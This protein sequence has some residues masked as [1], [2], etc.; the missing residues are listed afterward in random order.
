MP[1]KRIFD[2]FFS[3]LG[4][5]I[6][7]PLLGWIAWRIKREDG[8]PVFYRGERVGLRGKPFRI[9]KFRTM[10]VNAEKLGGSSTA[11]NDPRITSIGFKLRK[12]KLDELP[13][14]LNVFLGQMSLV[15]P[16]PEVKRYTDMFTAEEKAILSVRPG[17]TDWA[18]IWNPDEG[19]ILAGAADPDQAYL[20]LIRPTKV[21]LQRKYVQEQSF[22]TDLLILWETLIVLFSPEAKLK[23]VQRLMAEAQRN[24]GRVRNFQKGDYMDTRQLALKIRR[25]AVMMT[26]RGK[27]SHVASVLSM[28]DIVA[29]L[30]GRVLRKK[31]EDPNWLERDRF[32]LSKGHAGAGVYAAL[33]ETGYFP[34]D[35]LQNHCAQGSKLCGHV[36]HI[37]IPGVELSTGS[38]GHGLSVGAGIAYAAQ[39]DQKKFR[40]FVLL[41]D[42]ECDEGSNWEAILFAAHHRLGNLVAIIDYNKIQSLGAV[43]ETLALEPFAAK[44][45]AFGWQVKEVDGHDHDQLAANLDFLQKPGSPPTCVIAHTTKGKGVS[46]MENTV[47]WHYRSP[48]GEEFQAA[49]AELEDSKIA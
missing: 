27:S 44:W 2:I 3:A 32:I 12:H 39:V 8:G 38:L 35:W 49:L 29:V 28:A 41:S 48:Q 26:H 18:S 47:L 42:G 1:V 19:S 25:H 16:R 10:V 7:S 37:G 21:K 46:F 11:D 24:W 33:A 9:F 43:S 5:V 13:Q 40:V 6:L 4:L 34:T 22:T 20:E 15:G 36:S 17:I 23:A 30:Y 31:P 45:Q 14:L